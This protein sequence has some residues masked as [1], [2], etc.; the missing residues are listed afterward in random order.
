MNY[1]VCAPASCRR[2]DSAR[3]LLRFHV[4]DQQVAGTWF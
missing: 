3:S 2:A 1:S 4:V